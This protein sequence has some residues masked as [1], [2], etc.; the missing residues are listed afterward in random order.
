MF[1]L[2][3]LKCHVLKEKVQDPIGVK[4]EHFLHRSWT[5]MFSFPV[6]K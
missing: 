1:R 4:I 2:F 6:K 3:T 5:D